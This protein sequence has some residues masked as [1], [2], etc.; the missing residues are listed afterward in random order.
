MLC[1]CQRLFLI[2]S[3]LPLRSQITVSPQIL[4]ECFKTYTSWDSACG[5]QVPGLEVLQRADLVTFY[6]DDP[7]CVG[8][9]TDHAMNHVKTVTDR[10]V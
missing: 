6:L 7:D 2:S 8:T 4:P 3:L 10:S 5:R 9:V 1:T